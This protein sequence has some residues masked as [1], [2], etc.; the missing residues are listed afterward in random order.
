[1]NLPH[2][3]SEPDPGE[4]VLTGHRIGL[5]TIVR[6][7]ND[8]LSPEALHD[9]YPTLSLELIQGVI[10]FY[11]ENKVE[12]DAYVADYR[13]ELERQEALYG[14]RDLRAKLRERFAQL[15]P[16]QPLPGSEE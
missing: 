8:G 16:G 1:M 5:Y 14:R 7:Y 4:I 9:E 10:A 2:F 3:L 13:A 6:G 15:Y 11:L 12:V